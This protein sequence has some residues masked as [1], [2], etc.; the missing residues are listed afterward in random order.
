M[1]KKYNLY[2]KRETDLV[3]WVANIDTIGEHLFTFDKRKVYNLF[4]DY[5]YKL[6]PQERNVFDLE[7]PEWRQF[8]ADRVAILER[9]NTFAKEHG[10]N[11]VE[12]VGGY[13]GWDV[14]AVHDGGG[15]NQDAPAY[16][17][18]NASGGIRFADDA[19]CAAI[20]RR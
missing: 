13:N 7:N 20:N 16:I 17:I 5:P 12:H 4:A 11:A 9:V 19:E 10:F 8:F 15:I 3:W 2:R 1:D 14:F 18:A 6:T